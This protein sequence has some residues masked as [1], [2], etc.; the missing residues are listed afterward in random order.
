LK[1]SFAKEEKEKAPI[2]KHGW[3]PLKYVLLDHPKMIPTRIEEY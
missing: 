3:N 2:A 1:S